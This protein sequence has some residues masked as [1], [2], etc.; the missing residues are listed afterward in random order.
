M[1]SKLR[2]YLCGPI[3]GCSDS[4]AK[5]WRSAFLKEFPKALDPMRRDYRAPGRALHCMRE[6]V[7]LD[8]RDIRACDCLLVRWN[9]DK[10]SIG[11]TMEI[12]YA[13]TLGIPV[14]LWIN[15]NVD[16]SPWLVYHSTILVHTFVDA[17]D[18]VERCGKK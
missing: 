6:I 15:G 7:E 18:A 9:A 5:D 17:I 14:V 4:E 3:A 12:I 1:T 10:P 8:K 13:W 2:P 11:T 16:M